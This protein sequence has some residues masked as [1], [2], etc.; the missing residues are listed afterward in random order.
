MLAIVSA[1]ISFASI[2]VIA[3]AFARASPSP[4]RRSRR[5]VVSLIRSASRVVASTPRAS[6]RV[7]P[8]VV[9]RRT[10]AVAVRRASSPSVARRRRDDSRRASSR[11]R[12]G[13]CGSCGLIRRSVWFVWSHPTVLCA[14]VR[15]A[16]VGDLRRHSIARASP[17]T[18][19]ALHPRMKWCERE[20]KVY[21]TIE[22]P[23]AKDAAVTIE[24]REF[25][26]RATAAGATYE[27]R[28][29][30]FADVSKEKSTYAVTARQV[31]CVLIKEEAKWW[32]RLVRE[33]EKKPANLH[34]DFD[35]WA[36]EDDDA[37]D[38]DT[39]GFDMQSM[40]GGR[41]VGWAAVGCREGWISR[42][43]W[44]AWAAAARAA[45]R[46]NRAAARANRTWPSSKS[47]SRA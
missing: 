19:A 26:F 6:S 46:A 41:A 13:P 42:N 28:I 31:F 9:A 16:G 5:R 21:L 4:A 1:S 34:V 45:A 15:S 44:L 36:D 10:F 47:S 38:V 23:D 35:R 3:V 40:M 43:S 25:T 8:R 11:R 32:E 14:W 2:V 29:A 12:D 27:E 17:T 37:G 33:G 7:A 24:A 22:L 18:M 39:S 20:D 30:L